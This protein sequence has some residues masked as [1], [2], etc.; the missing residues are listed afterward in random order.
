MISR[1]RPRG[2]C[3]WLTIDSSFTAVA[4]AIFA[5]AG[6]RCR[7]LPLKRHG[8]SLVNVAN[9]WFELRTYRL[10]YMTDGVSGDSIPHLKRRLKPSRTTDAPAC[11]PR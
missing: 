3:A 2:E 10:T 6:Q 11:V 8:Y 7:S 9:I 4:N 1:K 5:A